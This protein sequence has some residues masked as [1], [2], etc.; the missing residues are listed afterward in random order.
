MDINHYTYRV[1]WSNEDNEHVG[2][3][4]EFPSLSF[5]AKEPENALKGIREVVSDVVDDMQTSGEALPLSLANKSFSG[6]FNVRIPPML[7]R[8]LAIQA[9]EQDVSLNR[10][11]SAKLAR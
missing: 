6:V 11:V 9:A 10:L 4:T 3:C 8:S 7:H 2:L 1:T 5:L